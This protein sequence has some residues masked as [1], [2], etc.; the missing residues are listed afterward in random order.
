VLHDRRDEN[1]LLSSLLDAVRAGRSR[2]LVVC[3]EAGVGKTAL[4]DHFVRQV[5]DCRVVSVSGLEAE[6]ELAFAGLHQICR[7]F[8]GGLDVLPEPQ[9]NAL[10][11]VFGMRSGPPPDP[12]LIGLGTLSLLAEAATGQPL[13]C[14]VDDA[15]WFD[16]ASLQALTFAAR[17]MVAE[18]IAMVFAAR[19]CDGTKDF[20]G[21]PQL[22]LG[23]L[24]DEDA[25][26]LLR[27]VLPGPVDRRMLD[28]I[29]AESRGIPLALLE[30]PRTLD[31]AQLAGGFGLPGAQLVPRSV[32]ETYVRALEEL[33]ADARRLLVIASA[34]PLGDALLTW[35]A[36]QTLGVGLPAAGPAQASGL[37]QIGTRF[38]FRHSLARSAVYR[39][40]APK[41]L[42]QA[43]AALAAVT[44]PAADPE[45]RAWHRSQSV[46][47]PDEDVA[48]DLED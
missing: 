3:G 39:S 25:R 10:S 17:R 31:P 27:T 36:A 6:Q 40:A 45:R 13:V 32:E 14:I 15:Q 37:V 1:R 16:T 9:R 30:V 28:Q 8:L 24:D 12:F 48:G 44:D 7:P 5:S 29:V 34:E 42:R 18:R 23:G 46:I 21:I 19:D 26:E 33:P 4:L 35:R 38:Q 41:E 11:T 47:G 22:A 20:A 43:H 2:S